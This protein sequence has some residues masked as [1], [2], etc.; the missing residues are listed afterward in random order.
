MYGIAAMFAKIT[1][2]KSSF[3]CSHSQGVADKAKRLSEY[4]LFD[5]DTVAKM[6]FAGALHDI[7]KLIIEKDILE[8]PDKLTHEEFVQIQNHAYASW[9]ILGRIDGIEDIREWASL[10]HEK[11]DG[12]GYPFGRKAENLSEKDRIMTCVDIYQALT[13]ERPYKNGMSHSTAI[14]IMREEAADGKLDMG[15]VNDMDVC[16]G[17][18]EINIAS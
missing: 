8:K 6:Y 9:D 12:S 17:T 13:E 2:Y 1:D 5:E 18:Q 7:G 14:A 15:I 11:L 3:T 10:H 4:Y 16:F